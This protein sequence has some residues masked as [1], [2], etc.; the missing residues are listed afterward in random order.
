MVALSR[1]ARKAALLFCFFVGTGV[2]DGLARELTARG[3]GVAD[4]NDG[5]WFR[6]FMIPV[7]AANS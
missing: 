3:A 2:M 5:K 1:C 7:L 6:R 4:G